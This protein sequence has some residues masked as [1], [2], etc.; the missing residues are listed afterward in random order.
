MYYFRNLLLFATLAAI[1]LILWLFLGKDNTYNWQQSLRMDKEQPYDLSHFY[2]RCVQYFTQTETIRKNGTSVGLLH[3]STQWATKPSVYLFAGEKPYYLE[4]ELNLLLRYASKGNSLFL[5]TNEIPA[6]LLKSLNLDWRFKTRHETTMLLR[7]RHPEIA[8]G[9]FR[10][11]YFERDTF[12]AYNWNSIALGNIKLSDSTALQFSGPLKDKAA[13]L[14]DNQYG[15]PYFF[16]LRIGE[17]FCYLHLN[18]MVFGNRQ[19]F[20]A[21]GMHYAMEVMRHFNPAHTLIWDEAA[22]LPRQDYEPSGN[23]SGNPLV[24]IQSQPALR[25]A[26]YTLLAGIGLLLLFGARS[27][28]RIIPSPPDMRNSSLEYAGLLGLMFYR[29]GNYKK[30]F[31]IQWQHFQG[32]T[33]RA[34]SLRSKPGDPD[35]IPDLVAHS[36]MDE[37]FINKLIGK[38]LTLES[39]TPLRAADLHS[40]AEGLSAFYS[41]FHKKNHG[42]SSQST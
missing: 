10:F 36:G 41:Q 40:W 17:G 32:F 25:A 29:S 35:F 26:W 12:K 28:Q 20:T 23:S 3:D 33:R 30:L 34:Y 37:I 4:S 1:G 42:L 5:I 8:K 13:I 16:R 15:E 21:E 6:A 22:K 14:G 18:P 7:L 38:A 11:R 9:L 2:R 24:Y 19:L 39:Q 27:M 31:T